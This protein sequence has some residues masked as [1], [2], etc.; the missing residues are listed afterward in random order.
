[1]SF[2]NKEIFSF[3]EKYFGIDLSDLSIKVIEFEKDGNFDRIRSYFSLDIPQGIIEDGNINDKQKVVEAIKSAVKEAGP[4][5]ISTKNAICSLPESKVFLRKISIPKMNNEEIGEAIKWEIEASIPL[6]VDQ[7][8]Y[9]WQLIDEENGKDNI[10]TVAVSRGIIDDIVEVLEGAGLKV[11]SLEVE[12]VATAR[13]LIS[14]KAEKKE[15]SLIVDFGAKKTSFIITEGCVPYFTS[16]IPFSS[17]GITDIIS[18][19]L[20]I[21]F[22]D[23]ERQKINYGVGYSQENMPIFNAVK[24]YLE[25]LSVE[26]ERSIDFYR[27]IDKDAFEIK[28]VILCGGGSNLKGLTAYLVK[29]LRQEVFLGDP[30]IN[31]DFGNDLPIISK[32]ISSQF[33]TAVGLAMKR[34]NLWK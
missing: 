8:Y 12:S 25:N 10:L 7:V 9:D 21:P 3:K 23:A 1:M 16:S 30:W 6:A 14:T 33:S 31:L 19:E 27:S 20:G 22:V 4:K 13:S 18:K 28:K 11:L 5:K 15:V 29:R 34:N 26:I 24:P 32:E 17:E 2:F